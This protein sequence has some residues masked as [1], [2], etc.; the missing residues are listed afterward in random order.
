MKFLDH[1]NVEFMTP[2]EIKRVQTKLLR[3]HLQYCQQHSPFYRDLF[4]ERQIDSD[5][6]SLDGLSELPLTGKEELEHN[7]DAFLATLPEKVIDIVFSSGTTGVPTRIVYTERDLER[8]AYNERQSF[9]SAGVTAADIVLL[10][11]TMDRCFVAGLAYLLGIRSLGAAAIRNG[12]GTMDGHLEII[13]RVSPTVIVG[14]PSFLLKLAQF[15]QSEGVNPGDL[16]VK[17][18]ICIGEPVRDQ[19]LDYLPVGQALEDL[20]AADVY[21]TYASSEIVT[22]FCE[23]TAQQ[24][25][26]LHPDLAIVEILDENN[27][28]VAPGEVGE[29][30]VTPLSVE[31]MPLVRFRTGDLSF[32]LTEPCHCLRNSPRLGPILARKKQMIKYKGTTLYPQ[33]IAAALEA[34]PAVTEHFVEVSS[35]DYLS[36][37][38]VVHVA[39][40]DPAWDAERIANKLMSR[41]R[42][43]PTI[44]VESL[45]TIRE[46]VF[47]PKCRKPVRFVDRREP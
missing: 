36:D 40:A 2:P 23:C 13:A 17:K 34:I 33:P 18:L 5:A 12:H 47:S 16:S 14:V 27:K 39:V 6:V 8:L 45:E 11:C 9:I 35:N 20:W 29:V 1:E 3:K 19:R 15:I 43:K 31:G 30:V 37:N 28:S 25:G 7:N 10:T 22:T 26:H 41:L 46:Q 38:I 4:A 24:G 21:S 42:V 44:A 32:L